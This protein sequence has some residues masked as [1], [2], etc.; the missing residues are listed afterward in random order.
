MSIWDLDKCNHL[1]IN[2][3]PE[4]DSRHPV[5]ACFILNLF[6]FDKN[7]DLSRDSLTK[8]TENAE[9]KLQELR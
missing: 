2:Y 6:S 4:M 5:G 1:N 3:N 7:F 8:N 9:K